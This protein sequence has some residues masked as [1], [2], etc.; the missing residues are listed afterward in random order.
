MCVVGVRKEESGFFDRLHLL[1]HCAAARTDVRLEEGDAVGYPPPT[2]GSNDI[3]RVLLDLCGELGPR[4]LD[5]RG[6]M[7]EGAF[8]GCSSVLVCQDV[9]AHQVEDDCVRGECCPRATDHSERVV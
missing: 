5:G 6:G 9:G 7:G 8:L 4:F 2:R 3:C 1:V